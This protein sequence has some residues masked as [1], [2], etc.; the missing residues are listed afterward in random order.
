VRFPFDIRSDTSKNI[1][2]TSL[3]KKLRGSKHIAV[4]WRFLNLKFTKIVQ[5]YASLYRPNWTTWLLPRLNVEISFHLKTIFFNT[6]KKKLPRLR[7]KHNKQ[8]DSQVTRTTDIT[9]RNK[10]VFLC[11][12]HTHMKLK[13]SCTAVGNEKKILSF[14]NTSK[15]VKR[16]K[17]QNYTPISKCNCRISIKVTST[18]TV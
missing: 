4:K 11:L 18:C 17:E 16:N 3:K 15:I 12:F 1:S 13:T 10:K 8:K 14:I 7:F 5:N 9:L 6:R 2:S